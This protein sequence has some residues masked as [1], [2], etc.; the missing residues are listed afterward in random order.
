[1]RAV[2]C[3]LDMVASADRINQQLLAAELPRI[4]FGIGVNSGDAIVGRMGSSRHK[5]YDVIGDTVNTAARL[6]SA[7]GRSEIIIGEETWNLVGDRL[8]V[9]E[10]EPLPLKGK[11]AAF[12][13]FVVLGLK[14]EAEPAPA[15]APA[16]A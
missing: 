15:T 8:E 12:R 10:T 2:Q 6:C 9:E 14:P 5:Q 1:M 16:P 13:T 11:S 7:A 3:A 4:S